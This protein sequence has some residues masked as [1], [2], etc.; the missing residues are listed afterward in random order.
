MF[1]GKNA[2]SGQV[3]RLPDTRLPRVTCK[4]SDGGNVPATYGTAKQMMGSRS[5]KSVSDVCSSANQ[6]TEYY[7]SDNQI[8]SVV[9]NCQYGCKDGACVG[10]PVTP[11]PLNVTPSPNVTL[12][13]NVTPPAVNVTPPTP[14]PIN[15]T[16]APIVETVSETVT[17]Q[18][19]G[20]AI[21]RCSSA[22]GSCGSSSGSCSVVITGKKGEVVNW[23]TSCTTYGGVITSKASTVLS[24]TNKV[25][26]I[27]CAAAYGPK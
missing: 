13:M 20:T 22:K 6:L 24:G 9:V 25:I 18:Y 15:V 5:I 23:D 26:P 27:S 11:P 10:A 12:P 14:T 19:G 7:C 17:C 21:V 8:L 4:D 3:F 1:S 2:A 16:P